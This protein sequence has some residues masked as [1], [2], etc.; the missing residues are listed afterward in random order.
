MLNCCS[1][2]RSFV[3]VFWDIVRR[4]F[5]DRDLLKPGAESEL[6]DPL[7]TSTPSFFLLSLAILDFFPD[8]AIKLFDVRFFR[9]LLEIEDRLKLDG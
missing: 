8:L 1:D 2:F 5:P 4:S 7:P 3:Y 9:G 6:S